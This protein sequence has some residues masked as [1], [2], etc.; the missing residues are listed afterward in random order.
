MVAAHAGLV[1]GLRQ[2][3]VLTNPRV[4]HAM[5]TVP[6]H[7][8]VPN[9]SWQDAYRDQAV[10]TKRGTD[11]TPVSSASQPTIVAAMLEQL[12]VVPGLRVLEIG[13]GSGYNA[14][15]LSC[16]VGD[17]ARSRPSISTPK[18]PNRPSTTCRSPDSLR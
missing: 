11:G 8:F 5:R 10:I 12:D 16:M 7:V 9:V 2:A 1:D 15:L 18:S 14:A 6:R 17:V 4:E 13:A 3:G